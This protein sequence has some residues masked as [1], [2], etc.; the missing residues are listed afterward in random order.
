MKYDPFPEPSVLCKNSAGMIASLLLALCTST[1]SG[2]PSEAATPLSLRH[3]F[4]ASG[5]F[6]DLEVGGLLD[7]ENTFSWE[8]IG[9]SYATET[10]RSLTLR[11]VGSTIV[12]SPRI[13]IG[14]SGRWWTVDETLRTA[15]RGIDGD[16]EKALRI[17]Y[18]LSKHRYHWQSGLGYPEMV[19]PFHQF[20]VYGYSICGRGGRA[21]LDYFWRAGLRGDSPE[22]HPFLRLM[23]GHVQ[24]E[25]Y[26]DG[27]AQ[28]FDIDARRFFLDR[29]NRRPVGGD[30]LAHDHDLSR[31]D[32]T[33]GPVY[34]GWT[35]S[36]KIAALFGQDDDRKPIQFGPGLEK[37]WFILRPGESITYDWRPAQKWIGR[38]PP[39]SSNAKIR[40]RPLE[41]EARGPITNHQKGFYLRG[42]KLVSRLA[43][44]EVTLRNEF[45]WTLVG[46]LFEATVS[47]KKGRGYAQIQ[48]SFNKTDWTTLWSHKAS[49]D[50]TQKET[51]KA[52]LD[53]D[54]LYLPETG[55]Q[56]PR[57]RSWLRLTIEDSP[58]AEV[59]DLFLES[60]V[61]VA[62]TALPHLRVGGNR[63]QYI[64]GGPTAANRSEEI[65][66]DLEWTEAS[67]PLP[68]PPSSPTTPENEEEVAATYI[69]FTWP[70]TDGSR[71]WSLMVST[72]EDF[73]W[74]YR[75][76]YDVILDKPTYR[77]PFRG[78][79]SH[80]QKYFWRV[81]PRSEEGYWGT[82][83]KTW[84]FTWN[85]PMVPLEV[86]WAATEDGGLEISWEPNPRGATP[87]RYKV[88]ASD[89]RGFSVLGQPHVYFTGGT[90]ATVLK[91]G[92][93][94]SIRARHNRAFYRVVAI[95][96]NGVESMPSEYVEL[97]RPWIY[98]QTEAT[99]A[100]GQPFRG[101]VQTILSK[102][103]LQVRPDQKDGEGRYRYWEREEVSFEL[104]EGPKW[105]QL[106]P[107]T[108]V[109]TGKPKARHAGTTT[110]EIRA[111]IT[112]PHEVP[113]GSPWA[114]EFRLHQPKEAN[115][116]FT[117]EVARPLRGA[118]AR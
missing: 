34:T 117:L 115:A 57:R 73:A 75:S 101:I 46:G 55:P 98:L 68:Q 86:A 72:R 9:G 71:A 14:D 52:R 48:H 78:M 76:S 106:D 99:A 59:S 20:S 65:E 84:S 18:Y 89:E 79:F 24:G 82:W 29:E 53:L 43:Y 12:R 33:D 8:S 56:Q 102:G 41:E 5:Q 37:R 30:E 107:K 17:W 80:G 38:Q 36:R 10:M 63:I 113:E 42:K 114:A 45:P 69:R 92:I 13:V 90:A 77:V 66:V 26:V 19:P 3:T 104:I 31:R 22:Q 15:L 109:L 81:R 11:N 47:L 35:R 54:S 64:S 23:H 67:P 100:A 60:D 103:D 40:W 44:S 83:S 32:Y 110:I 61:L 4:T 1:A 51:V 50:G 116:T 96:E 39:L 97:P 118:K 49:K 111:R 91:V 95:D 88:F 2:D 6:A 28:L 108:G 94:D 16:Q 93:P 87:K 62:P 105:L 25:V 74:P 70:V 21:A 85:G 58:G 27:N 112:N 7:A